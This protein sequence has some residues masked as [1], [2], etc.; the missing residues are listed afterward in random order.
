M[1]LI[2]G[3][4]MLGALLLAPATASAEAACGTT[5]DQWVGSYT[6][7][8][9]STINITPGPVV[10]INGPYGDWTPDAS[11]D[12]MDGTLT[13]FVEYAVYIP[14]KGTFRTTRDYTPTQVTCA[15][16]QVSALR[17]TYEWT[18]RFYEFS[19]GEKSFAVSR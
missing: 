12:L 19:S 14:L 4:A 11:P 3:V 10:D 13:F 7:T 18:S 16:G 15:D 8:G 6:G 2:P 1:R 9:T 5:P 17:G